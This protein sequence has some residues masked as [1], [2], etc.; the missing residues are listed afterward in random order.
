MWGGG[1]DGHRSPYANCGPF[2]YGCGH[3]RAYRSGPG[4]YCND[5]PRG[6]GVGDDVDAGGGA[7]SQGERDG[8]GAE[9]GGV[10]LAGR[11]SGWGYEVGMEEFEAIELSGR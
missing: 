8:G 3:C 1:A 7:E 9:G 11:F 4:R 6:E 2:A 10:W 5:V